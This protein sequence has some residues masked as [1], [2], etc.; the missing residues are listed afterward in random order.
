M[1]FPIIDISGIDDPNHQVSIANEVTEACKKWGFLLLRGHP[2]PTGEI[3]EMFDLG[4]SFFHLNESE[5]APYPITKKSI[6]YIGSFQDRGKDD[7]MSM[8]FGGVPGA[9]DSEKD[10]LPPFWRERTQRVEQFKHK[11]HDL[12]VKLLE[13]FAL[14]LRLED[15]R[16]FASAH[17][18]DAGNGN[19]LRMLMYPGRSAPED[20][21]GRGSRMAPHTDS[22]SVTLLFQRAAGLE[23]ESPSGEWVKAPHIQDCILVN[24]GDALSFWSGGMLKATLHRVT[25]DG[26]PFDQERQSMAYFGQASPETVLQPITGGVVEKYVSNGLVLTPGVTV[27]ELSKMIMSGIYGTAFQEKET[28]KDTK[29]PMAAPTAT[30]AVV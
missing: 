18:E 4:R 23:V 5:K 10:T 8:W 22:G 7:K 14:S 2:I 20:M 12:V 16:F 30:A 11:C 29:P 3:D 21:T 17:R 15:R 6:G 24:L 26:V 9:L 13:C 19:A 1:S 28:E 27:G 25:F